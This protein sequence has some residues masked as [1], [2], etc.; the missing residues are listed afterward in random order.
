MNKACLV[1]LVSL[2]GCDAAPGVDATG[3]DDPDAQAP[4]E[5]GGKADDIQGGCVDTPEHGVVCPQFE[6][7]DADAVVLFGVADI[8]PWRDRLQ[9]SGLKPVIVRE[10]QFGVFAG[11]PR[12][13]MAAAYVD[14]HKTEIGPYR[15]FLVQVLV[16]DEHTKQLDFTGTT[17]TIQLHSGDTINSSIRRGWY[18]DHLT[19]D[20]EDRDVVDLAVHGGRSLFGFPKSYGEINARSMHDVEVRESPSQNGDLDRGAN[21]DLDPWALRMRVFASFLSNQLLPINTT[22]RF[23]TVANGLGSPCWMEVEQSSDAVLDLN[24]GRW[25]P[26]GAMKE[27]SNELG[28]EPI[29]WSEQMNMESFLHRESLCGLP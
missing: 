10:I 5:A 13:L 2:L 29:A 15:E 20:G 25:E 27:L 9:G 21:E 26:T 3:T 12:A 23:W 19:L 4:A 8:Q 17:A 1:A 11:P 28:F 16:Q 18:V 24:N 22:S 7:E 14:Y 6:V